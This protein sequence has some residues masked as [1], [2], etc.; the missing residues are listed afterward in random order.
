MIVI[1]IYR[2]K[3]LHYL[4]HYHHYHLLI[5]LSLLLLHYQALLRKICSDLNHDQNNVFQVSQNSFSH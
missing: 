3:H 2:K 1:S 4:Y 5:I